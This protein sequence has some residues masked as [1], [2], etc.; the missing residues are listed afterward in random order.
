ML[1]PAALTWRDGRPYN[2]TYGDIYHSADGLREVAR[3]FLIPAGFN[4]G[5]VTLRY[6]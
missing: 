6:I 5:K 4:L 1:E 3:M 2:T